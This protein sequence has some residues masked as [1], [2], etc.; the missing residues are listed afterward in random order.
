MLARQ[1]DQSANF[2]GQKECE[3]HL[4][5]VP[6]ALLQQTGGGR[7]ARWAYAVQTR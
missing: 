1:F 2:S 3:F 5:Y 7:D 6:G 4:A